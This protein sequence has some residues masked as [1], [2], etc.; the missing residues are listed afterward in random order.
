[1]RLQDRQWAGLFLFAGTTQF[2][3][4]MIIAEAVDPTYSVSMN[5]ISDLGVRAGAT[6]FNSS[7]I[8]L[9]ITILAT[10]W[11]LLRAFKDRILMIVVFLAGVGAIGVGVFTEAFGFIHSIV[12][13]ITFLFAALSAILAFRVLRP[14]M[15][16]LSV[17]LGLG[18]LVA[19]GL[20]L[21]KYYGNL[22][23]G[24]MERMIVYPVLTWGIGFGGYL[25]GMS[26][27]KE[28][29]TTS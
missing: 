10:A 28:T 27:G 29:P 14:P 26:H 20:Y 5:Y 13:F 12:S 11:F 18:S 2:A 25:L 9:G 21:A 6:V 1:M 23:N 22:G 8:I 19:L 16:Y 24:G 7:I 3:I 4:G 17:L 15:Q